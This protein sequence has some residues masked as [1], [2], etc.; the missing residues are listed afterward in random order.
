MNRP[1]RKRFGQ[2]FLIDENV[3]RRITKT[4]APADGELIIEI[5]PGRAA[6]TRSLLER[7]AD[8]AVVEIDRD[9]ARDL[10]QRFSDQQGLS[11]HNQDALRTD[12]GAVAGGRRYRLVGNLPYNISTPLIF[13][14]LKLKHPPVDMHF[15]LQKEVVTRMAAGPGG[16]DYG[17]L[18][19]MCRNRCNV[20]PLFDVGPESF[21]P[22]PRVTSGFVRLE[23]L[24]TPVSGLDME[25]S[26][27]QVVR[28]AF[29]QRRKTLRNSL[30]ALLTP[31]Q[32]SLANADPGTRAEQLSLEQFIALA[33]Q[34]EQADEQ[35][36]E[37]AEAG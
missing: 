24:E 16:R 37:Q 34:L 12:F 5:G 26:L 8:I 2:N 22:R 25:S 19:V 14:V 10:E 27:E 13:H 36:D 29:S 4:I 28:Q 20:T 3:I 11:I 32:I 30:S 35:A 17:R 9:L 23:P 18:S 7:S 6:L 21:D 31:E 1:A 33:Q 15:M